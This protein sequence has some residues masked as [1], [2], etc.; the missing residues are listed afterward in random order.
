MIG[1]HQLAPRRHAPLSTRGIGECPRTD[2]A[3]A[4]F[5]AQTAPKRG[6]VTVIHP[7]KSAPPVPEKRVFVGCYMPS[8]WQS[9]NTLRSDQCSISADPRTSAQAPAR[10]PQRPAHH[11][12][13]KVEIPRAAPSVG[14]GISGITSRRRLPSSAGQP[15]PSALPSWPAGN[16][17]KGKGH[18]T[19]RAGCARRSKTADIAPAHRR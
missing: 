15:C 8:P 2:G 3:T 16:H 19:S 11:A 17:G 7:P 6:K 18:L 14:L 10:N 13:P 9:W 4:M 12:A 5:I 1:A